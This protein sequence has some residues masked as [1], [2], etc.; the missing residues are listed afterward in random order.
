M[1]GNGVFIGIGCQPLHEIVPLP[2]E[3]KRDGVKGSPV[4]GPPVV[5]HIDNAHGVTFAASFAKG[6]MFWV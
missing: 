4:I 2:T 1:D 6:D 3:R 5:R